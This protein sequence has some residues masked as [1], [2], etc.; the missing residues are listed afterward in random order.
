MNETDVIIDAYNRAA[1]WIEMSDDPSRIVMNILANKIIKMS[2]QIEYLENRLEHD[3]ASY[4][5]WN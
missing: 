4:I 2:E 5:R 1:E 3:S